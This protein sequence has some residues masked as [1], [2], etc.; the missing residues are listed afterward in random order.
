MKL[1]NLNINF[2]LNVV[3]KH[4]HC[5]CHHHEHNTRLGIKPCFIKTQGILGVSILVEVG[6]HSVF[7]EVATF[8]RWYLFLSGNISRYY[9]AILD[10]PVHF[11]LL[12]YCWSQSFFGC[13]VLY[14]LT[15]VLNFSFVSRIVL[16]LPL[17]LQS[18]YRCHSAHYLKVDES[19]ITSK[20]VFLILLC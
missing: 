17:Y 9:D 12:M 1:F 3:Y 5:T 15:A 18:K 4:Q 19:E 14:S 16:W 7:P 6:P 2:C 20:G 11:P 13:I 8:R 10:L